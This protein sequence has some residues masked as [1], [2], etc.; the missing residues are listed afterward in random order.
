MTCM[1]LVAVTVSANAMP[2]HSLVISFKDRLASTAETC[3]RYA[4][5]ALEPH[6]SKV[7][8]HTKLDGTMHARS[9]C[10]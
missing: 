4:Q 9:V 3:L 1:H 5:D 8:S 10:A 7:L 2:I 6:M